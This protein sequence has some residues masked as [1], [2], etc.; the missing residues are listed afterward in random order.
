MK[1]KNKPTNDLKKGMEI[2]IYDQIDRLI[3]EPARLVIMTALYVIEE[4]DMVFLKEQ[5][6]LSWGNLSVQIRR[7]KEARYVKVKKEF[8]ENKPHTVVRL[9][10]E[11]RAA[12]ENYRKQIKNILK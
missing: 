3:H 5:T 12:F 7:L 8:L 10:Q 6:K 9:T 11:G 4:G 1:D 2:K